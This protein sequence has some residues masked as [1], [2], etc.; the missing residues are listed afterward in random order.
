MKI[1]L[2]ILLVITVNLFAQ[3]PPPEWSQGTTWYQIF[4]ERF[5]NGDKSN[6]PSAEKVF[7]NRDRTAEAWEITPWN[8]NWFNRAEWES[9]Y[10][11]NFRST[12]F[13][14]RYGGD[15]QGIINR[16]DYIKEL[17]VKTIYLNPVFEAVSLHK[18]DGST[19]HH[20]DVNFGPNPA[21]D[22]KI[23]KTENPV[24]YGNWK[25]TTADSL[26]LRLIEEV[27]QRNM[28]IVI[29]GVFNH[30]GVQFWAF[31]KIMENDRNSEF[32]DWYKIKSFDN[33]KTP[34]NELDHQG[35]WGIKSLP[36][37]NRTA[38][39]LAE[40]PKEYIFQITQRWMDPNNDGN[41]EDGIDGWRLDVAREVPL[42]FWEEW[43]RLVKAIN[44]NSII[45]GELWELS[46]DMVGF[47]KPFDT[48]MNY[49]FAFAVN[50]FFIADDKQNSVDSL[51][52]SLKKIKQAYPGETQPTLL[53]LLDSHDTDR[54]SS[55]IKNPDR[56]YDREANAENPLYNPGKPT[57]SEYEK[58]KMIAAFQFAYLGSPMIFYGDEAG[59]WGADDP[60]C[61][62]PMIWGDIDYK[63]EVIKPYTGFKSG[64]GSY[65]VEVNQ[66]LKEFYKKLSNL[67]NENPELQK[68]SVEFV[69]KDKENSAFGII[70]QHNDA[71][72][73]ALFNNSDKNI[74]INTAK[75]TTEKRLVDLISKDEITDKQISLEANSYKLIKLK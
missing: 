1:S 5:A 61:R 47:D 37:F 19:F 26:F 21:K 66:E 73:L 8:S 27:H 67:R 60:H 39:D 41:P 58:Q 16:L 25:W 12:L 65:E 74:K 55:M 22:S 3:E 62:K 48:L 4:P 51:I 24:E 20:I 34:E 29:D 49:N 75:F 11:E 14:R 7:K 33:P 15:I 42:D 31:Q 69:Y 54:L 56:N 13:L 46:P 10:T 50:E 68:G 6:D 38:N 45:V 17:G 57:D 23:I 53:N 59:M 32:A 28:K 43:S 72:T 18:Y 35:W 36:E 9:D 44:P 70:R 30:T 2:L 64:L 63:D 52:A 40:G 71:K